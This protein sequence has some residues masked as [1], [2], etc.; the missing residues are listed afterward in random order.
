[1]TDHPPLVSLSAIDEKRFG[2]KIAKASL[3][4]EDIPKVM[5]FCSSNHVECLIARCPTNDIPAAQEMEGQDFL[6]MDTIAYYSYKL[7]GKPVPEDDSVLQVRPIRLGE[8]H[9]V[10]DIAAASFRG[11]SGHYHADSKLEK[12]KCD[13][14]YTDWAYRSCLSPKI[15]NDMLAAE[16]DGI[17]HGFAFIRVNSPS[18]GEGV[19][20]GVSPSSQGKG[21]YR[22]LM[23]GGIRCCI[24]RGLDKMV[25]ST[26]ITNVTVQKV[27]TR[28]GF[29]LSHSYYTF[30]KWFS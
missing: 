30:H 4:F 15:D 13:E 9:I 17:I 27:W 29:E 20:F 22:L 5:E 8:E 21:I 19:L 2:V 25:V 12:K 16:S 18:V 28:L 10:K 24:K 11:Y 26:Q 14:V 6:L 1:M 23:I 3:V 7:K